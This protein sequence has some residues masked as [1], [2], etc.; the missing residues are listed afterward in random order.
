[1][2]KKPVGT[3]CGYCGTDPDAVVH[4]VTGA[5]YVAGTRAAAI[6]AR[7]VRDKDGRYMLVVCPACGVAV[8]VKEG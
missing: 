5:R 3:V 6:K 8:D 4:L 1:M 7:R 2:K